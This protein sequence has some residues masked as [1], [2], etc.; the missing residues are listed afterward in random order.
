MEWIV[1]NMVR[2]RGRE[3]VVG[4][5][6]KINVKEKKKSLHPLELQLQAKRKKGKEKS[7]KR[8]KGGKLS[9]SGI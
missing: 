3:T 7:D 5:L 9:Q 1:G 2:R 6:N 8:K 4:M